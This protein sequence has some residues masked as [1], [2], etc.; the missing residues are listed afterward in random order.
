MKRVADLTNAKSVL[1]GQYVRFGEQVRIDATLQDL[2]RQETLP[3]NALAPS[4][5]SFLTALSELGDA[6]GKELARGSADVVAALKA[7][8]WKPSTNSVEALRLYDDG[9]RLTQQGT[10][11]QALKS[12]EGAVK[13]DDNFALGFSALARAHATLGHE[14]EAGQFS[15]RAMLLAEAPPP[16]EKYLIASNHYGLVNDV[17]K[18]IESYENLAKASPNSASTLF[19]LGKLYE[20]VGRLDD[21]R[22][23][24]AKV[25]ELDPKFVDG[26]LAL[27]RVDPRRERTGVFAP[28]NSAS[29]W[30]SSQL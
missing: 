19:E 16:Q 2:E 29:H 28:L 3:L 25:V 27:G 11:E 7:S 4:Q 14:A 30:P 8:S 21:A 20:G 23:N 12:F 1:W 15:R 6:V 18:A 22:Q 13:A 9:V 17:D 24:F 5:A 10:H 26:L